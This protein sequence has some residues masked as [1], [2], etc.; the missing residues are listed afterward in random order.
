MINNI[1]KKRID[2]IN[3]RRNKTV[4]I[5]TKSLDRRNTS[6]GIRQNHG[7]ILI[8]PH[9][10]LHRSITRNYSVSSNICAMLLEMA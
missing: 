5:L 8:T 7:K 6:I 4:S 9:R 1:C 2:N 3:Q 10:G